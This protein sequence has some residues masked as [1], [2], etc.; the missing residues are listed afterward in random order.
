MDSYGKLVQDP[1][2]KQIH[3]A[4]SVHVLA[5][6]SHGDLLLVESEGSF[7]IDAWEEVVKM[8]RHICH[9]AE[10]AESDS[11]N[12]PMDSTGELSL[13]NVMRNTMQERMVKD[14]RWRESQ[15]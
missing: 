12:V 15:D 6:S 9:G 2:A 4:S 3:S 11:Q 7:G 1:S 14:Q 8:A 10:P 5:F 13:E